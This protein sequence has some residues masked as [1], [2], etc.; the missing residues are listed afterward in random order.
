MFRNFL[1][2]PARD[3]SD[4][5]SISPLAY[6]RA[7]PSAPGLE[8][9]AL[10]ICNKW[11]I[12][13]SRR[14]SGITNLSQV[15]GKRVGFAHTN[16]MISFYAKVYLARAGITGSNVAFYQNLGFP[17]NYGWTDTNPVTTVLGGK[18]PELYAHREVIKRVLANYFDVGEAQERH[19]SR[20]RSRGLQELC[21][22]KV[23][24]D[25][26]VARPGLDP[27]VRTALAKALASLTDL[28]LLAPMFEVPVTGF[29]PVYDTNFNHL[30]SFMTN[31]V[32]RFE[33]V[34]PRPNLPETNPPPVFVRIKKSS[35]TN[36]ASAD[37]NVIAAP[38]LIRQ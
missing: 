10:P 28:R 17:G 26:Y 2:M 22:F 21:R 35:D 18:S 6:V 31:E 27:A 19:F 14:D 30:R 9:V 5:I 3:R 11:A 23:E 12:I 13:F 15:V 36:A 33:C 34:P 16:T 25:I 32:A 20:N 1:P 37:S 7:K 38:Y 24:Q 8:P 29:Q 4:V